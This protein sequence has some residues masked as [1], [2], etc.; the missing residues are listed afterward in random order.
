M[1]PNDHLSTVAG[2]SRPNLSQNDQIKQENLISKIISYVKRKKHQDVW[3][4][5]SQL[6]EIDDNINII[7]DEDFGPLLQ[8][9]YHLA[10]YQKDACMIKL[11][12]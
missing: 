4:L 11:F 12:L 1:D 10:L 2:A 6:A 7:D 8:P 3:E 9:A 5:L